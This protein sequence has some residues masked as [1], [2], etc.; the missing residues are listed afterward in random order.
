MVFF[1]GFRLE[2]D[3]CVWVALVDE[4]FLY[5]VFYGFLEVGF[6]GFALV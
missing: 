2:F 5:S 6:P 3:L 4:V 1:Y